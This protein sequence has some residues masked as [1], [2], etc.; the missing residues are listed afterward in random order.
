MLHVIGL[1]IL[2]GLAA[3]IYNIIR[4]YGSKGWSK[5]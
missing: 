1:F 2:G 5:D 4:A 3:I